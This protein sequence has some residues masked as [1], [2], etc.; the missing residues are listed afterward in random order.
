MYVRV[1]TLILPG[2]FPRLREE[3]E[4]LRIE[5]LKMVVKAKNAFQAQL[6]Q[7]QDSSCLLR[8]RYLP[9]ELPCDPDDTFNEF[10]VILGEN[11]L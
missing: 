6:R 4:G 9:S 8:S 10:C 1:G 7:I 5:G 2:Q 3:W 11:A